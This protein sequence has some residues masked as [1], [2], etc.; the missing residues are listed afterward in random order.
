MS[1]D[2]LND[3]IWSEIE[4][5]LTPDATEGGTDQI[6]VVRLLYAGVLTPFAITTGTLS[7]L[8][9][10]AFKLGNVAYRSFRPEVP[11]GTFEDVVKDPKHWARYGDVEKLLEEHPL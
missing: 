6:G 4:A 7:A 9:A 3:S 1:I 11:T 5:T 10:A 2:V 8:Q